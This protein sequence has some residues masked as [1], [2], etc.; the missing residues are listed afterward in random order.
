MWTKNNMVYFFNGSEYKRYDFYND[1]CTGP[2]PIVGNWDKL[3][4]VNLDAAV[5]APNGKAYFFKDGDYLRFDLNT[6]LVDRYWSPIAGN[7]NLPAT[8]TQKVDSVIWWA[9]PGKHIVLYAKMFL[10]TPYLYGGTSPSTGFDCSGFTQY[11]YNHY[12]I[13]IPRTT[14]TQITA[15]TAVSQSNLKQG[16]LVFPSSGHVGI[17]VGNGQIIHSPQTGDVVKIS[18]IW[19]FY[20][21]RRIIN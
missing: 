17:Y 20:A 7:W 12:H 11:V 14:S 5:V 3:D 6:E 4:R 21:A 15:G 16:D 10:G 1:T 9:E 8:Y 19:S 2:I 13:S 18:N